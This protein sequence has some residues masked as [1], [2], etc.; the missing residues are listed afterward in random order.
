MNRHVR[1]WLPLVAALAAVIA[2]RA[3]EAQPLRLEDAVHLALTRNERAR[4]ADL[5]STISRAGVERALA[6]FL[7]VLSA[8]GNDTQHVAAPPARMGAA[9]SP[10]NIA[11]GVVQITQPLVSAPAWPLYRQAR[12]LYEAQR[13]QTVDDK[14]TL[15]FDASRSFLAVLTSEAVLGAAER[16]LDSAKANLADTQARVDAQ[17]SSSNDVTRAQVDLAGAAREVELDRGNR[18]DAYVLLAFVLAA[19]VAN[20]VAQPDA[21]MA[22]ADKPIDPIDALVKTAIASR[23]DLAALRHSATAAHAFA[24]EPLLRLVPTLGLTGQANLSTNTTASGTWHDESIAFTLGWTIYDAGVR[25]ADKRSRDASAAIA[26]LNTSELQ[27][28]VEAQVR[29][30]VAILASAQAALK[31]ADAAVKAARQNVEE[32]AI[33]YRQGLAKAIE[34]VDANDSRFVAEVNF[35]QAE[36]AMAQAYLNLRQ[37][38]GLNPFDGA[39]P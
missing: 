33:L 4:I 34:L 35:S 36:Y 14:R 19:P 29:G 38:I 10:T 13:Y 21:L 26:D 6:G 18:D 2:A 31:Q 3:A 9:D 23:P 24:S 5:Q 27:R 20:G 39:L 1:G 28:N 25:Y 7:P 12:Q 8:S 37:A 32:T 30:A 11:S 22:A 17:L 15:A 16:R